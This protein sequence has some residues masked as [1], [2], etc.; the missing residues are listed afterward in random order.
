[1]NRATC[2][3]ATLQKVIYL[4]KRR[5]IKRH[6]TFLQKIKTM[7]RTILI[8]LLLFCATTL[9]AQITHTAQGNYD[10]N[11]DEILKKASKK[12]DNA[13]G[14]TFTVTMTNKDSNKKATAKMTADV[15]YQQGKYRVTFGDNVIY[16]DGTATWHWNK[17]ANE[18]VV[19]TITDSQDDL[20]NP[21]ALLANYTKNFKAKYIRKESNG[22]A[23]IDLTPKKAKSYYKIRFIIGS[24]GI[25][26][27][28]EMH[29]Y[30][31]TA[32]EYEV[33]KFN[34][35]KVTLNTFVFPQ[36]EN[37]GVEIIDMR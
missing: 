18:V 21:G 6:S 7:K 31:S 36:K 33:S 9:T 10:K 35:A 28:M 25:V 13:S 32:A 24:N 15:I 29:N 11:A 23:V 8:L 27:R 1:M 5:N 20:M 3:A 37:T 22:D 12:I 19:N 14:V 30:D 16:C 34:T 26:K 4:S 2:T 17:D